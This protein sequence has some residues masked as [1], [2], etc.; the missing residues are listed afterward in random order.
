LYEDLVSNSIIQ[1][2]T[3]VF[4]DPCDETLPR[5]RL[6]KAAAKAVSKNLRRHKFEDS[7]EIDDLLND[8][9]RTQVIICDRFEI[10]NQERTERILVV[11]KNG[12]RM[13]ISCRIEECP[14]KITC[15]QD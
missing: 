9:P 11:A 7:H 1:H 6:V 10:T 3:S 13:V 12:Q 5:K 2:L 4:E 15:E 14:F 8:V